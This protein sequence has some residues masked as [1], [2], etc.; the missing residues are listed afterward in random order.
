MKKKAMLLII[1]LLASVMF[2]SGCAQQGS[3]IKTPE[4]AGQVVTD[5]SADVQNVADTLAG[6]DNTLG[7]G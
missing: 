3:S 4:E 2:I 6:I 1:I 7:G 5:V